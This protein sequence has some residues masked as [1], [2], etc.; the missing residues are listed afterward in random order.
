MRVLNPSLLLLGLITLPLPWVEIQ[1]VAKPKARRVERLVV[2]RQS[3]IQTMTGDSSFTDHFK[4]QVESSKKEL[5]KTL[6]E[7]LAKENYPPQ[8]DPAILVIVWAA[9]LVL[10]A[11]IGFLLKTSRRRAVYFLVIATA[12]SACLVVQGFVVKFPLKPP[13]NWIVP[14]GIDP[15]DPEPNDRPRQKPEVQ[16]V[17]ASGLGYWL[18]L[19]FSAA[20]VVGAI[21][22][23]RETAPGG[24]MDDRDITRLCYGTPSSDSADSAD[25]EGMIN[26]QCPECS[27]ALHARQETA[28]MTI[29]CQKC[30][31]MITVPTRSDR[32]RE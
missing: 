11:L 7:V 16:T 6:R 5:S 24:L 21:F 4:Q 14:E 1:C 8:S 9:L 15:E 3:G 20:G 30:R 29:R 19:L 28:G 10:G 2:V 18:A 32:S 23:W 27:A 22:E 17:V 26:Y 12:A 25:R 31:S 13:A